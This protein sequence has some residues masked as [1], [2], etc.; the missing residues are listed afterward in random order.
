LR[1]D[2]TDHSVTYATFIACDVA[3]HFPIAGTYS[4]TNF[5][6]SGSVTADIENSANA[7]NEDTYASTNQDSYVNLDTGNNGFAQSFTVGG[8][9]IELSGAMLFLQKQGSPTGNLT[10]S[11]YANSGGLPTGA[12]LAQI[13]VA[14][15]SLPATGAEVDFSFDNAAQIELT[16]ST[17]YH[18]AIEYSAGDAT[19]YIQVGTD[20]S[21]HSHGGV[22]SVLNG[23]WAADTSQDMIFAVR[24]DGIVTV[25]ANDSNPSSI[26]NTGTP[27]GATVIVN[28]VTLKVTVLDEDGDPIENA[29][30]GIYALETAGGVTKGDELID[31]SGGADTNASGIV[32]N[33]GFNYSA[34]IDVE[35]RSRKSSAADSP[36]YKH[37]V[38]NQTIG[39]GGL[40]VTVTLIEDSIAT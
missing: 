7:T 40:N 21:S 14:A 35:V 5:S 3:V 1:I 6:F 19:N 27:P 26:T 38:S 15:S 10:V 9:N 25:N 16:A 32:Q 20:S 23:S 33:T 31:G 12:A 28:T 2:E 11:I 30:T 39:S 29:Q 34:D 18:L 24:K 22:A 4:V 8:S 37:L 13:T 36:K 17:T